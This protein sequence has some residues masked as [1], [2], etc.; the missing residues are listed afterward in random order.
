[1]QPSEY[2]EHPL[3]DAVTALGEALGHVREPED[4]DG[5]HKLQRVRATHGELEER[6]DVNPYLIDE[7]MCDQLQTGAEAVATAT[8]AYADDPE[9]ASA[10]LD[11]AV[12]H[13][14]Q[15]LAQLRTW[16]SPAADTATRATKKAATKFN[17]SV[18]EMIGALRQRADELAE[19]L[20]EIEDKGTAAHAAATESL[21]ELK[22]AI[23]QS[24][25][26]VTDL[27]ARL[28][29]QMDSQRTAFEQ[30][31]QTRSAGF[32][33]EVEKL[34]E[35]AKEQ[36]ADLA[37]R[38]K[39]AQ[40]E[41]TEKADEILGSLADRE[42]RARRLL[43]AT[44]RHVIAGDYGKWA[45]RQ[46]KTAIAWTVVTVLIG[47]A[48]GAAMFMAVHG[49][50]DDSVQFAVYKTSISVIGLI[51]AG[52]CARQAAEH[53]REE[54][55]NKKLHL[56]LAAL[57][58]FLESV[59]DPQELR[60]EIARRVFVPEKAEQQDRGPRFGVRRSLNI[61]EIAQLVAVLKGTTPPSA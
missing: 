34:R 52:Y 23:D 13:T 51:V 33:T 18:D 47:L 30:E 35:Q 42:D 48:T 5:L 28:T 60:T 43:D 37:E 20:S 25:T 57:E 53:R 39:Q 22:A 59:S 27:A 56:D 8:S 12:T 17:E 1:M 50:E 7:Q 61:T 38:T 15:V 24:Q 3:W 4:P 26:E 11:T 44:S 54:R 19:R 2:R 32:D 9:A 36:A 6:R 45:A 31:A 58:P 14:A 41:Q 21:H 16:P 55:V 10:D 49:A 29:S 46:A 40:A